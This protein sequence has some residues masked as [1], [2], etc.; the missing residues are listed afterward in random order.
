ME[1]L[2]YTT[3]PEIRSL[4]G[5]NDI[6][7]PDEILSLD[8][9]A[10]E[11]DLEF[12]DVSLD[13]RPRYITVTAIDEGSRTDNQDRFIKTVRV[14]AAYT[15][16]KSLTISLPMFGPKTV[17]DSKTELSRFSNDPF[18]ATIKT[19]LAKWELYKNRS[20]A[21][22]AVVDSRTTSRVALTVMVVSSPSFDPV[23]G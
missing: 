10:S 14:F 1:L 9:Y 4:L 6:E 22:L 13:L 16:A 21:A 19:V 23:T 15:V 20:L 17:T 3:Y 7:L 11:L 2:D 8:V 18:K 12:D 5:V